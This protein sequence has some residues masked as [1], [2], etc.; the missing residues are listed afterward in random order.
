MA[1]PSYAL[2]PYPGF[3]IGSQFIAPYP[4]ELIVVT[5][6]SGD[7]LIT[8][9]NHKVLFK[10]K[11]CN[12]SNH[13]QRVLLDFDD[14]PIVMMREKV[15]TAHSGWKV[16]KGD[17]NADSDMIFSKKTPKILQSKT[18]IHVFLG[19]K[20]SSKD[21]CDFKI[22][23]SWSK[24]SCTIY[25]G[26]SSIIIAQMQKLEPPKYIK[27]KFLVK[28]YPYVDYAFVITLI[29]IVEAMKSS[30]DRKKKIIRDGCGQ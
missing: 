22:T 29:A 11:P 30:D 27:D 17:S 5:N 10:V 13:V 3:V 23:G 4:F 12:T 8:D 1:Q 18:N 24:R 15:W 28:I 26:D 6:S 19:N 25:I 21:S 14:M 7:H 20:T 2:S 16:F 9:V